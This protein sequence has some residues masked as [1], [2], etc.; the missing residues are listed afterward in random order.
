MLTLRAQAD[1]SAG[2][3]AGHTGQAQAD[4][5]AG[6]L[7]GHT[8]QTQ[9]ILAVKPVRWDSKLQ[10]VVSKWCRQDC[11][12]SECILHLVI[13]GGL[14]KVA[15]KQFGQGFLQHIATQEQQPTEHDPAGISWACQ[16][17]GHCCVKSQPVMT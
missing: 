17:H 10:S 1:I 11:H 7:A 3:L 13:V 12:L 16:A 5:S 15:G 8:G 14:V 9:Q 4:I 6:D 2:D